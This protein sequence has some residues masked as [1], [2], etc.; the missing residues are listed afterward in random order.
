MK[1]NKRDKKKGGGFELDLSTENGFMQMIGGF[2]VLRL[3]SMLSIANVSF[4]KEELLK[5]N[6][7]LNKIKKP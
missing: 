2:S 7:Q 1:A 6:R 4:T 5:F 3:T